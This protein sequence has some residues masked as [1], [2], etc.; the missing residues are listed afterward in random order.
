MKFGK[1]TW[2]AQSHLP[3]G[4][5]SGT[6][7]RASCLQDHCLS[8]LSVTTC[9]AL[10]F[11]AVLGHL[12]SRI[13][14]TSSVL[15]SLPHPQANSGPHAFH[16]G[17]GMMLHFTTFMPSMS[18]FW[19]VCFPEPQRFSDSVSSSLPWFILCIHLVAK[20]SLVKMALLEKD[21]SGSVSVG[22]WLDICLFMYLFYVGK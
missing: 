8:L 16:V 15:Q 3:S 22:I 4:N 11:A 21:K 13:Q 12:R 9:L 19:V 17:N 1:V 18:Y 14:R 5:G 7:N 6:R 10:S 2:L 20:W